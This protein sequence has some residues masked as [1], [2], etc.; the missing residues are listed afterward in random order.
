MASLKRRDP[1]TEPVSPIRDAVRER[2]GE[3]ARRVA[4]GTAAGEVLAASC[5]AP[6]DG[7]SG[8]CGSSTTSWDPITVNLYDEGQ[9]AGIPAGPSSP[10]SAAATPRRSPIYMR[11][12]RSS[13]SA[14]V[15][16]SM[17]SSPPSAWGRRGRRTGST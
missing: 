11:G 17:S 16:G 10:P 14:P 12:R 9:A 3:A 4:E 2:Y 13:T 1:T 5:C 6:A 15:E 8:C 7:S